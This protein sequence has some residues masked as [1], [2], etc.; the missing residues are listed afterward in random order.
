[1]VFCSLKVI[2][3]V[4]AQVS[5]M[6]AKAPETDG[7]NRNPNRLGRVRGT[8]W[9]FWMRVWLLIKNLAG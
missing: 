8:G 3:F 4:N 9:W 7:E 2:L 1:M 5:L 6:M